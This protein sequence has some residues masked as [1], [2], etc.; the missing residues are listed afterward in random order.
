LSNL[1]VDGGQVIKGNEI[2]LVSERAQKYWNK[3]DKREFQDILLRLFEVKDVFIIPSHP[4]D[5]TA[6]W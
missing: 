2:A 1:I 4:E 3:L 5:F 6:V